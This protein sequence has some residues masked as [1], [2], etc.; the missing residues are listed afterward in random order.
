MY[1]YLLAIYMPIRRAA[2]PPTTRAQAHNGN[3]APPVISDV[4]KIVPPSI[5]AK[6]LSSGLIV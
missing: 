2:D 4:T 3:P 6:L 5:I 1:H